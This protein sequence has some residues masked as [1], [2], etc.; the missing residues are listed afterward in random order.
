MYRKEP[1]SSFLSL[2]LVGRLFSPETRYHSMK[3]RLLLSLFMGISGLIVSAQAQF[4][5]VT[6]ECPCTLQSSDGKTATLVYGIRNNMDQAVE[7]MNA[8]VGLLTTDGDSAFVFTFEL[9]ALEPGEEKL[10][11]TQTISL[12][13]LPTGTAHF[14]VVI[15][16]GSAM[17]MN[18]LS[19]VD[20]VWFKDEVTSPPASLDLENRD[21]LLDTDG[22][23][24]GD[25]NEESEGTDPNDPDS[26]PEIP[27]FDL[28]L[29]Y[30]ASSLDHINVPYGLHATHIVAVTEYIYQKS[31][32]AI[33][34]RTVGIVDE[35]E[36][37]DL[38]DA[39]TAVLASVS[40]SEQD[41]LRSKYRYDLFMVF[42]NGFNNNLCGIAES[43][44][45]IL[46]NGFIPPDDESVFTEVYL[47]P[48]NCSV[49]TS[50]HELG[51]LMG[52][53]HSY[54]Q[55]AVGTFLWSRGHGVV[56]EFAT[57]M[58]YEWSYAAKGIHTF[59]N[60]E[61]DC[62]GKPCGSAHD[63]DDHE[64]L[65]SADATLSVN[66]V[67]YQIA[68]GRDPNPNFDLD[69]DGFGADVD[70]FPMNSNEWFD[71]DGDG[72]GDNSDA[73]KDDPTEWADTDGDG[74]GDNSDP[75]IDNDGVLNVSDPKPFNAEI[76][77]VRIWAVH[78]DVYDDRFGQ[79]IARII[80]LNSDAVEEL[81]VSAPKNLNP[82]E[83]RSGT[84][85]LFSQSAFQH[86]IQDP[87]QNKLSLADLKQDS[88]TWM[89]HGVRT[90]ENLG[91]ILTLLN[92]VDSDSSADLVVSSNLGLYVV[93]LDEEKLGVLDREDGIVDRQI[94]LSNC[95]PALGCYAMDVGTAD[96]N[97]HSIVAI[98][99]IDDDE[100]TDLGILGSN[101][102]GDVSTLFVLTHAS[103]A[104]EA[105]DSE[106]NRG[107]LL[108]IWSNHDSNMQITAPS[109]NG[110]ISIAD[111]GDVINGPRH[112]LA[113]G[114]TGS[115]IEDSENEF[116]SIYILSTDQFANLSAI[117][118]DGERKIHI[119]SFIVPLGSK[120][121]T[122]SNDWDMGAQ[123]EV[124]SDADGDGKSDLFSWSANGWNFL[125]SILP[126]VVA[127]LGDGLPDGRISV[128]ENTHDNS[129][130]WLFNQMFRSRNPHQTILKGD[131]ASEIDDQLVYRRADRFLSARFSDFDYLDDPTLEDLNSIIN[132]PV[133]IRYPDIYLIKFPFGPAGYPNYSG[134][135]S[136]GDLDADREQDFLVSVHSEDLE[137]VSSSVHL[138]YSTALEVLDQ[139][140]GM[141]DHIVSMHNN[142]EDIDGDGI[143]NL[144]DADDDGDG[145]HD[146]RDHYPV[147]SAYKY[148]ADADGVANALDAFP[149]DYEEQWDTDF[150]GIGDNSDLDIDGDGIEN[151]FDPYPY[152]TDDDGIDNRFDPDDDNDGTPDLAD[153][154]PL[155]P[156]ETLDS[157]GD[158]YGD[159][160]DVFPNDPGEWYDTDS[161]GIGNNADLDDDNDTYPD[162]TDAFPLDPTEWTDRDGDGYGD[163]S[164][165]F[166]D[167]PSEWE[168]K[169]GDGFGDNF[170]ADGMSSYLIRS[171]WFNQP[172]AAITAMPVT[173]V[174]DLNADGAEEII[175]SN[176]RPDLVE[177]PNYLM[178][179]NE[180]D[181]LDVLDSK[182]DH[183]LAVANI[184]QASDS[185]QLWHTEVD[186]L[187][188]KL[189]TGTFADFNGD[190]VTDFV[191]TAPTEF[192]LAGSVY[193]LY[194]DDFPEQDAADGTTDGIIDYSGCV[195][196]GRCPFIRGNS[197][198]QE[199]GSSVTA[200]KNFFGNDEVSLVMSTSANR[201]RSF[202]EGSEAVYIL[203][204][205]AIQ[206]AMQA[207][208]TDHIFIQDVIKSENTYV[209]YPESNA[210]LP[211]DNATQVTRVPDF[212]LDGIHDLLIVHSQKSIAYLL[213][214]SDLSTADGGDGQIDG[215]IDLAQ[216][217]TQPHSYKIDGYFVAANGLSWHAPLDGEASTDPV[218]YS[219]TKL[220]FLEVESSYLVRSDSLAMHDRRDGV[221]DGLITQIAEDPASNTW[222]FGDLLVHGVC[223][224][225][226]ATDG[227]MAIASKF[228][229]NLFTLE[230]DSDIVLFDLAD[231]AQLDAIDG[232][233]D[234]KLALTTALDDQMDGVWEIDIP[235]RVR[236]R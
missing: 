77:A 116:G 149:L 174:G 1:I 233:D 181:T 142:Y 151:E 179:T 143:L 62:Y 203:S 169:D 225:N 89:I 141:E 92:H 131:A 110:S 76:S 209:F 120:K 231:L 8:T 58:T 82:E 162:E 73:F 195:R 10:E 93:P 66:I 60:P 192:E 147:E 43:I 119:D 83:M 212:D 2:G 170:G 28:L 177:G 88:D 132:L 214:S 114:I 153:A 40:A 7:D 15:H 51:H 71:S 232:T 13:I 145:L 5:E 146:G 49:T 6:L 32:G 168:D 108:T 133:R 197:P 163:N 234:G 167:D 95:N 129:N 101:V 118:P 46:D 176:P 190:L 230:I 98:A 199:L 87:T 183:V 159:V 154:F 210:L 208:T 123:V 175:F 56:G 224:P 188:A 103:I 9:D 100:M 194:G 50:A 235:N 196:D 128:D 140:D 3:Y 204:H 37:E 36:V 130:I 126:L 185:W 14:N 27:V 34:F 134:I 48:L 138:I 64:L 219:L 54:L 12:G 182:E 20:T 150:D 173:P 68:D 191:I 215:A 236:V 207:S 227:N 115:G 18:W 148:D 221:A 65:E 205:S 112:E 22:D 70:L 217:R 122:S 152:D 111:L 156:T 33:K 39:E 139:A 171:D 105:T 117:D 220:G 113:I 31:G 29:G 106:V 157:D 228:V 91:G 96:F 125:F 144:H 99:D 121:I 23:G 44:T 55:G 97:N 61:M 30:Q 109:Y 72:H 178:S 57:V 104:A 198:D 53:G 223:Q 187:A 201:T 180:L 193:I 137:G 229:I 85:Y 186:E 74:I 213:A 158:G 189:F 164:D 226:T 52:L 102:D 166:P 67:K 127:D 11:N 24:I 19:I 202:G 222:S 41:L 79:S 16:T 124:V 69:G 211:G 25:L 136:L 184:P 63:H 86:D 206:A 21:Y 35:Q 94:S 81:A 59:S 160:A 107:D 26:V 172:R 90:D 161:D 47:D 155:D 216:V 17:D 135:T 42:R 165:E 4:G 84:V 218:Y 200:V 80:D 45:G 78:S 38:A 75:D